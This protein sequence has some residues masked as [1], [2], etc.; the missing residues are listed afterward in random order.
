MPQIDWNALMSNAA[1]KKRYAGANVKFF[2]SYNE[3]KQKSLEAGRP[4]YDEIPSIS[5]QWPGCDETVRRVEPQDLTDYPEKWAQFQSGNQPIQEGTP[6]SEWPP[7]PGSTLREF[8]HL[9]FQTVEQLAE[10]S[11]EIKRRLGPSSRF[12]K[13]AKDWL[14]ASNSSQAQV[15][16]L[17]QQLEREQKRTAKLEEQVDLL[18][19]RIEGNEGI[20]LR[21]RRAAVVAEASDLEDEEVELSDDSETP[22]RRGRPRK[23]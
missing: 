11:D 13:M 18:I 1:P 5:I 17:K 16:S 20:D 3:N 21:P 10:A 14:E 6:L 23:I 4:I 22:R 7:L 9:G 8:Q 2:N 12:V 15:A 19:Q